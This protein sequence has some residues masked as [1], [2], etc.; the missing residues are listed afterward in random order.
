MM[1]QERSFADVVSQG[2][3]TKAW[4]FM[5]DSIIRKVDKV[6][7]RGEDITVCLPETKIEDVAEKAGQVMGGGMGS[8]VLVQV[9]MNNDEEGTSAIDQD[10]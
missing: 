6:V 4:V 2:K 9:G 3:A 10:T 5:V 8:A 1:Q 7:N